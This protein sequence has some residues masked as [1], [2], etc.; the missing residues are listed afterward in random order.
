MYCYNVAETVRERTLELLC[1]AYTF[2]SV[3]DMS[4]KLNLPAERITQLGNW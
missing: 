3:Q 2:I 4:Q 1:K